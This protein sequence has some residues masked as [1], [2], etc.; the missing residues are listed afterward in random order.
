MNSVL[1]V[2]NRK[3]KCFLLHCHTFLKTLSQRRCVNL[4]NLKFYFSDFLRPLSFH[5]V[6]VTIESVLSNSTKLIF[7]M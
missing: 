4:P 3:T 2:L 1:G 5:M 7:S 6:I